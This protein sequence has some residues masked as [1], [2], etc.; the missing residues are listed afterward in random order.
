MEKRLKK[1]VKRR[2]D[3]IK[4]RSCPRPQPLVEVCGEEGEEERNH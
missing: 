4:V 1:R 2:P 3:K